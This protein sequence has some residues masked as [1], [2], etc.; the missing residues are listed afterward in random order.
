[1]LPVLRYPEA[2]SRMF[3]TREDAAWL[4]LGFLVFSIAWGLA[5]LALR[6]AISPVRLGV[7]APV[8]ILLVLSAGIL[9]FSLRRL[10]IQLTGRR[11]SPW[12]FG[13]VS[14]TTLAIAVS[15]TTMTEAALRVGLNGRVVMTVIYS[16]LV[17]D[18]IA[19]TILLI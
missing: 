8:A 3:P 16:V 10:H 6:A 17:A 12:P 1:M 4:L 13:L 14:M 5:I 11:L 9:E 18:V 7:V 15:P 19:L 2:D